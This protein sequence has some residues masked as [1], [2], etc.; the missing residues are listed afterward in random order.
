MTF[1]VDGR[2]EMGITNW[3][4]VARKSRVEV[5]C[6][7]G[8]EST[9]TMTMM[10]FVKVTKTAYTVHVCLQIYYPK[11]NCKHLQ[12][13]FPKRKMRF[14]QPHEANWKLFNQLTANIEIKTG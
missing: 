14:S 3:E 12:K 13:V 5:F 9:C 4:D 8:T 2:M 6:E 11:S 10:M 7:I 1:E